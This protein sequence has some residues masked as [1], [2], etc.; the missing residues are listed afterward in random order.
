MLTIQQAS[1]YLGVA[2]AT[3]YAMV[4]GG[5]IDIVRI[6]GRLRVTWDAV[7]CASDG[8]RV[9]GI[10]TRCMQ[11]PLLRKSDVARTFGVSVR[12]VERWIAD[13]LPTRRVR[14]AVRLAPAEVDRWARRRFGVGLPE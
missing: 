4:R 10:D 8:Q 2:P 3:V 12:T 5:Q 11:R 13:G 6:G 9:M 14:R 7:W 1:E